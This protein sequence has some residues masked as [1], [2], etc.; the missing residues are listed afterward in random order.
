MG[1]R[2]GFRHHVRTFGDHSVSGSLIGAMRAPL[3][4]LDVLLFSAYKA[5]SCSLLFKAPHPFSPL[6][7]YIFFLLS[8]IIIYSV[9]FPLFFQSSVICA[10]TR[11]GAGFF[12]AGGARGWVASRA[13]SWLFRFKV[14]SSSPP[15]SWALN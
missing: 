1:L 9:S 4:V 2:Y 10:G 5:C 14:S 12:L 6:Y 3:H 15:W 7:Y 13:G 11:T 8:L